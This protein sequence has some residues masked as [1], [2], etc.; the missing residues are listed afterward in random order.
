MN[1]SSYISQEHQETFERYLMDQMG[2]QERSRFLE[3]LEQ[4]AQ[5]MHQF[6]EFKALFHSVEETALRE[7]M[8]SFHSELESPSEKITK[9]RD[10]PIYKIAAVITVLV[11]MGLWFLY[12][13]DPNEKLYQEYFTADPGL[14]T[15]MGNSSNYAFYEA[16][17][18]Y[19][20][21]HYKTAISKWQQLWAAKKDNDTLNYFLGSAYLADGEA[22]KAISFFDRVVE[23]E[24]AS[25]K[26]EAAFYQGL[27]HLKNGDPQ[28]A[29]KS[30]EKAQDEKSRELIKKLKN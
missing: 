18:D 10:F 22:T 6:K 17:V 16:M 29:L 11:A 4:D 28:A 23:N 30:L 7:S 27:A 24:Q 1:D 19:K 12:Q 20:Q 21:G 13:K 8:E 5:L 15:V 2:D 9:G 14:P 3:N 25:F 26:N